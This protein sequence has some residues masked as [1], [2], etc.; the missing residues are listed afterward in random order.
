[1]PR[2]PRWAR[3]APV[4]QVTLIAVEYARKGKVYL[5]GSINSRCLGNRARTP[6][7]ALFSSLSLFMYSRSLSRNAPPPHCVTTQRR[8]VKPGRLSTLVRAVKET[9]LSSERIKDGTRETAEIEP[10]TRCATSLLG[11]IG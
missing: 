5:L 2:S 6:E 10:T 7:R 11:V 1:M 4:V 8:A 9:R 3:K